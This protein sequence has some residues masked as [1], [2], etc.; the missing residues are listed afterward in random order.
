MRRILEQDDKKM[1]SIKDNPITSMRLVQNCFWLF[2]LLLGLHIPVHAASLLSEGQPATQS[3]DYVGSYSY[4]AS[5]AVDGNTSGIAS[6]QSITHTLN[7]NNAWWQVDLNQTAAIEKVTIWNRTDCCDTRLENFY[8]FLSN[9]DMT[10]QTLAQLLSNPSVTAS[11]LIVG[12]NGAASLDVLFNNQGARYVRVQLSGQN[13]LHL[14]EVQVFGT[15]TT[16]SVLIGGFE[17]PILSPNSFSYNTVGSGWYLG[18]TPGMSQSAG[19]AG[20]STNGSAFTSGAPPAPE[21]DQQVFILNRGSAYKAITMVANSTL[22]FQATQRVN[23]SASEDQVL[24]VFV[25]GVQVSAN[26]TPASGT[27]DT[28]TVALNNTTGPHA[29]EI[30]GLAG[31]GSLYATAFVDDVRLISNVAPVQMYYIHPD[32]LNTP[33]LIEDQNQNTVWTWDNEEPFG[34]NAANEDPNN[35]GTTFIYN[36]RFPGQYYDSETQ[37]HYNYF[38][39][40]DPQTGRYLQSDP[41]GLEGGI[42]TY[43]Y[44]NGNPLSFIDVFGLEKLNLFDPN[45]GL[46][47]SFERNRPDVPGVLE[48]YGHGRTDAVQDDRSGTRESLDA[49]KLAEIIRQ[50]GQWYPGMPVRLYGCN[51]GNTENG[52]NIAQQLARELGVTVEAPSSYIIFSPGGSMRINQKWGPFN[53]FYGDP[54]KWN[55]FDCGCGE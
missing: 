24:G 54:G 39:D 53:M 3:S 20:I 4:V 9:T 16:T 27:W 43:A 22:T 29:L 7:D 36:H 23:Y 2:C 52:T 25:D 10:G 55:Q 28:F 11:P 5:Y 37:T 50:D 30:R 14:A 31:G 21:G 6:N 45:K 42:N 8:V 19:D 49:S 51:T 12:L 48:V 46:D 40:Y 26:L 13:F 47:Q 38:R 44:V 18:R 41:I 32:H 34:N 35:T 17:S 1:K 15:S 33:R